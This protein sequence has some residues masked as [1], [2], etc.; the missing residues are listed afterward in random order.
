[1]DRRT[2]RQT[3]TQ[4][5]SRQAFGLVIGFI[6]HSTKTSL[7]QEMSSANVSLNFLK[8]TVAKSRIFPMPGL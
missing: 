6:E 5:V 1:M 4:I 2:D 3:D 8:E 7:K